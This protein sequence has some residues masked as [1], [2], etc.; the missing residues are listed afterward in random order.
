MRA[1][2]YNKGEG[3]SS[4]HFYAFLEAPAA[5]EPEGPGAFSKWPEEVA[6]SRPEREHGVRGRAPS[7]PVRLRPSSEGFRRTHPRP[8]DL[9][10]WCRLN[11]WG[12][13]GE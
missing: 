8:W 1:S 2:V 10:A 3:V 11:L 9:L 4:R 6:G 7:N 5:M 13:S 12:A